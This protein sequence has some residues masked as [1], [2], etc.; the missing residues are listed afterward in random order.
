MLRW[1][2]QR[3]QHHAELRAHGIGL[4]EDAHDLGRRGVG[5]DIVIGGNDA[6][7]RVAHAASGE[8]GLKAAVAQ[9]ANDVGGVLLHRVSVDC[10]GKLALRA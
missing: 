7:Q 10:S 3:H 6:E 2:S 8:I 1:E 9:L 5:G 4:R